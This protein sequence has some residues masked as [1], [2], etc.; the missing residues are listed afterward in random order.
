MALYSVDSV[1]DP[2]SV[3]LYRIFGWFTSV[4][5]LPKDSI[6]YGVSGKAAADQTTITRTRFQ[7]L[8][9]YVVRERVPFWMTPSSDPLRRGTMENGAKK[10]RKAGMLTKAYVTSYN[11]WDKYC[12]SKDP[13]GF[14]RSFRCSAE[15][16]SP[17]YG[18]PPRI[19]LV[20]QNQNDF[21]G[22]VLYSDSTT[23]LYSARMYLQHEITRHRISLAYRHKFLYDLLCHRV[24]GLLS[25]C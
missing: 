5:D 25:E 8:P 1:R 23:L 22:S 6:D 14:R 17:F 20:N 21:T 19:E 16:D 4:N 13:L 11:K 3:R 18:R 10:P 12:A 7:R 9:S 24:T 15:I 2:T